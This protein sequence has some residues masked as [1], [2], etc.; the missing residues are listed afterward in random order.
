[1]KSLLILLVLPFISIQCTNNLEQPIGN[2]A[3]GYAYYPLEVGKYRI[4]QIDSLQ[5]DIGVGNLPVYDSTTYFLREVTV[6]VIPDLEDEPL[7]R[8]ERSRSVSKNGPW[9]PVDVITRQRSA[10]QAY[11][12]ENNIRLINLVFPLKENISWD[13]IS[14]INDQVLIFIRGESIEMYKGWEFQTLQVGASEQIGDHLFN[15]IATVQQ[16]DAENPFEKRLSLEKYA[17]GVGLVFR[18]RQIVDSYCKYLGDNAQCIGLTWKEKSG[19][20]FFTKEVLVD[21]N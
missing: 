17:K 15:E 6:E 2:D 21:F 5:F 10:N 12:T 7:Y 16:S 4:Y 18:E 3:F 11:S 19:R 9:T 1:M 8:I 20:G 13:G 14:Y